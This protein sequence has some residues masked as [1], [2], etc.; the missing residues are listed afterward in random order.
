MV[1]MGEFSRELCG[2]THADNTKDIGSLLVLSE[3]S[4]SSGT[5]RITALT[6]PRAEANRKQTLET[7]AHAASLL[8]CEIQSIADVVNELTQAIRK[9][10]K[11]TSGTTSES[12]PPL[13]GRDPASAVQAIKTE[14]VNSQ[15]V[16]SVV[17][18]TARLL[19]VPVEDIPTRIQTLLNDQ[20]SLR[21]QIEKA[22]TATTLTA[23]DLIADGEVVNGVRM[24][25]R[26]VDGASPVLMRQ[27]I[28][29]IR[30]TSSEPVAIM[31]AA[32]AE[33]DKVTLIAALSADLVKQG[34]A[35]GKWIGPVAKI[36]GGGAVASQ[37]WHKP[38]AAMPRRS[39]KHSQK[40]NAYGDS[41]TQSF[42]QR[43]HRPASGDPLTQSFN[44]VGTAP[45]LLIR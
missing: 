8:G 29:K 37:I 35:A 19:N 24:I 17:R 16:R 10:K 32:P 6:G 34:K 15:V 13:V 7:A 23:E 41:L 33:D 22:A 20:V 39:K 14:G 38:V 4:I 12:L 27:W 42:K 5:R 43:G 1:S 3:E 18:Q 44:R 40:P 21:S 36:L 30:S 45:R 25:I 9:L 28:D 11:L 2:G 31:L 26:R